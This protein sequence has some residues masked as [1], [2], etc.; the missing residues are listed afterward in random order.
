M[1]L[2]AREH[3]PPSTVAA[4]PGLRR[5]RSPRI[6]ICIGGRVQARLE[7]ENALDADRGDAFVRE[8][9]GLGEAGDVAAGIA[10]LAAVGTVRFHQP[11]VVVAAHDLHADAEEV[12]DHPDGVD[13]RIRVVKPFFP[14]IHVR[15]HSIYV[16]LLAYNLCRVV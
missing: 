1:T 15:Q 14:S 3:M 16:T 7:V 5:R 4:F 9:Q 2:A 8:A 13:G 12:G 10:S 6:G 11:F